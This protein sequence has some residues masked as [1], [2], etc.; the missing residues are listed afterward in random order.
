MSEK[1]IWPAAPS[2]GR[3]RLLVN[4]AGLAVGA[5]LIPKFARAE[6]KHKLR[7]LQWTHF[8]P[9]YDRWFEDDFAR[10]WGDANDTEV[11]ID[12]VGITSLNSRANAEVIA[13]KG[14]DLFMFLRPPPM[15]EDHVIDHRELYE[16][17]ERQFGKPVDL[18]IRS[19]YN[20]KTKKY[21][22]FSESF[23]PDPVNYRKDLWDDVGVTPTSW[24]NIL[25]GGTRIY[26]RHKIPVGIGLAPELDSNMAL[27]SILHSFGGSVQTEDGIPNL[28][29]K[30][31]IEAVEFVREL[32]RNAMTEEVLTWDPSSNNRMLLAGQG[33]LTL[34]AISITR[35]GESQRIPGSDRIWIGPPARG[36]RAQIGLIH[37]MHAYVIWK[38][39]RNKAGAKRFLVDYTRRFRDAF[40]ASNFYNMPCFPGTVPDLADLI[41]HDP[42]AKPPDKYR[43]LPDIAELSKT[44]GYPGYAN[45]AIDEIFGEWVISNM[46]AEVARGRMSPEEA[47]KSAHQEVRR[48]FDKWRLAGKI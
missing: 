19:T 45:A 23:V 14:H 29:S 30:E 10:A 35:T 48:I 47:V 34:N 39:A 24:D 22:G 37:L 27:R 2:P 46:F 42:K 26:Q 20:P 4:T 7:I 6:K 33:S 21:F 11:T 16:E 8:V 17:C 1:N 43:V 18:A 9:G 5:F 32:Y 15:Y 31:T 28:D 40:I 3:R 41:K 13:G 36:P 44:I 12:R 38:F 25:D